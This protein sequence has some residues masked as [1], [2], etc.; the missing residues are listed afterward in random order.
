MT[1]GSLFISFEGIDGAGKSTHIAA[2][3]DA[4]RQG[5]REVTVTREPG[6]TS[7]AEKIRALVLNDAMDPIAEAL[8]M[9]AARRDH[10]LGVIAPT[11]ARGA[12][13]L[14]DRYTDASFAYQGMAR[15]VA[16]EQL[17][18]LEVMVQSVPAA[19][20]GVAPRQ[21][22][23]DL[24][25]WLDLE[26]RIAAARLPVDRDRFERLPQAFFETVRAGY[27]RRCREDA[28]RFCRIDADAAPKVVWQ[29]ILGAMQTRG[30][31]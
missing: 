26:P 13:V 1:A 20:E 5:G 23:P 19:G 29:R 3:A 7:L 8:L 14:C 24:T 10:V 31:L 18:A 2:L 22:R 21:I 9:F 16:W 4:L 6:G 28:A 30:W 12:V 17:Q 25:F 27:A 11:L 15:G